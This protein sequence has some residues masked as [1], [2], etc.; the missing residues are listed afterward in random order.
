[1]N[2]KLLKYCKNKYVITIA[3]FFIWITF[4]DEIT[5]PKWVRQKVNNK[6]IIEEIDL[7][8]KQTIELEQRLKY[9][10]NKDSLEKFAR[11]NYY[12][13]RNNEVIYIFD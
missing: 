7:L 10:D 12:M 13:K 3:V 2:K 9:K 8:E 11:E 5:V 6:K 4:F 1:V